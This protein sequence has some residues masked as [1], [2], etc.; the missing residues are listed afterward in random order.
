MRAR[1]CSSTPST[2]M[3]AEADALGGRA[4]RGQ[5]CCCN[6][7]RERGQLRAQEKQAIRQLVL[8]GVDDQYLVFEG[9]ADAGVG[10]L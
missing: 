10:I 8:E 2:T 5:C 6:D 7:R 3:G 1:S 9:D 4:W